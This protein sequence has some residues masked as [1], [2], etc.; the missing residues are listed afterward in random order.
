VDTTLGDLLTGGRGR[1][2]EKI[3]Q[4]EVDQKTPETIFRGTRGFFKDLSDEGPFQL[5]LVFGAA[6]GLPNLA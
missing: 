3:P 2:L 5:Q 4:N 6:N 1:R